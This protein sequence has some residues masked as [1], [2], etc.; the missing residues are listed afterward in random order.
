MASLHDRRLQSYIDSSEIR[1][2]M[3]M[4]EVEER[5]NNQIRQLIDAHEKAFGEM[6]S[7]YNDI[8]INNLAL[9][10]SIKEQM[11]EMRKQT[12]RNEKA[13]AEKDASTQNKKLLEP[14]KDSQSEILELRKKLE[15]YVRDKAATQKL[16][17]RY[18]IVQKQFEDLTWESEAL[19]M[20]CDKV[21]EERDQLKERFEEAVLEVQQKSSN[22]KLNKCRIKY[23][24]L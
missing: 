22:F 11:E 1:H 6:K 7:Y 9:I 12:E 10:S 19:Q 3:E 8:T 23:L 4:S 24:K 16:Q 14:Q 2:R 13:L 5:K 20:Q 21:I 15:H 18:N 17:K